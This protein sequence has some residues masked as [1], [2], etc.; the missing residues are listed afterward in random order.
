[1]IKWFVPSVMVVLTK[2]QIVISD[3]ITMKE[4]YLLSDIHFPVRWCRLLEAV[5]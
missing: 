5:I 2:S 3:F 1:M 4:F